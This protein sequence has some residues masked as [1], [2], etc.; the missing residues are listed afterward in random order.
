[1]SSGTASTT[2]ATSRRKQAASEAAC[3]LPTTAA[4]RVFVVPGWGALHMI[5]NA[6]GWMLSRSSIMPPCKPDRIHGAGYAILL[7]LLSRMPVARSGAIEDGL[8]VGPQGQ[9]CSRASSGARVDRG[10]GTALAG[11]TTRTACAHNASRRASRPQLQHS[12]ESQQ[13]AP[14]RWAYLAECPWSAQ[15]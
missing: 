2:V 5:P 1:M 4:R 7:S 10:V 3:S 6:A 13:L 9:E 12:Q 15:A 14:V 11:V 8:P